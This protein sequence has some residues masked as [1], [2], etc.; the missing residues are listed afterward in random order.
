MTDARDPVILVVDD[1]DLIRA[2]ER[3]ILESDGY[4]VVDA[5]SGPAALA[6]MADGRHVDLLVADLE[7]PDLKGHEMAKQLHLLLPDLRVLYVTG[8]I[9]MLMNDRPVLWEG[10]AFLEKPFTINGLK[11]AVSLLLFGT[12]QKPH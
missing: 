5:D 4:R 12:L 8:H 6:L 1:E 9:D 11:E 10:E 7:M 3:R 2:A